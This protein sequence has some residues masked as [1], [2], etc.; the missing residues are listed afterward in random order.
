MPEYR[1]I[2]VSGISISIG[3]YETLKDIT[4]VFYNISTKRRVGADEFICIAD[5]I[6]PLAY[7]LR[8]IER[9]GHNASYKIR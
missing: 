1:S 5:S 8:S 6:V 7:T 3:I 9:L 4:W 2:H